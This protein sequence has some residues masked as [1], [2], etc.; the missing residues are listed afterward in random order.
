MTV[1]TVLAV[2]LQ[3]MEFISYADDWAFIIYD[4]IAAERAED[5]LKS[6]KVLLAEENQQKNTFS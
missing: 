6:F 4:D 5:I 1:Q 2:D 3:L